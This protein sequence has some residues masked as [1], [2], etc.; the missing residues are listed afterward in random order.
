MHRLWALQ[1]AAFRWS[2]FIGRACGGD[3]PIQRRDGPAEPI[4]CLSSLAEIIG[5]AKGSQARNFLIESICLAFIGRPIRLR[6]C[7]RLSFRPLEQRRPRDTDTHCFRPG[8][9]AK[10]IEIRT[11]IWPVL[12]KV[13]NGQK[14][15]NALCRLAAV[16]Q[17]RVIRRP[18]A[19]VRANDD[20]GV[21]KLRAE[22]FSDRRQIPAAE[23]NRRCDAGGLKDAGRGGISFSDVKRTVWFASD[24]VEAATHTTARQVI[25]GAVGRDELHAMQDARR[26]LQWDDKLTPIDFEPMRRD[27]FLAK[28]G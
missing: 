26:V 27:E 8:D 25:L 18:C 1:T 4:R 2:V 22:A 3:E 16:S 15:A 17:P 21:R 9:L 5:L 19:I 14:G 20:P 11:A 28:Y 7:F 24:H 6:I 23:A 10:I 13:R 12:A